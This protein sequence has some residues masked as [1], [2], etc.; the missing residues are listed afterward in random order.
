MTT[1]T[2][3]PGSSY[4]VTPL[5]S[6]RSCT[7]SSQRAD[8]IKPV[9]VTLLPVYPDFR[10][11]F[12]SDD[13]TA[14]IDRST[15]SMVTPQRQKI[16]SSSVEDASLVYQDIDAM[17]TAA[18]TASMHGLAEKSGINSASNLTNQITADLDRSPGKIVVK[19]RRKDHSNSFMSRI[20][21]FLGLW[22][23]QERQLSF[24]NDITEEL[25]PALSHTG[26]QKYSPLPFSLRCDLMKPGSASSAQNSLR[27]EDYRTKNIPVVVENDH[28]LPFDCATENEQLS[29]LGQAKESYSY[30]PPVRQWGLRHRR[31]RSL[32]I[33]PVLA[34]SGR[35][36]VKPS[37]HV[38]DPGSLIASAP[39]FDSRSRSMDGLSRHGPNLSV[40]SSL[41]L[42]SNLSPLSLPPNFVLV[43]VRAIGLDESGRR[44]VMGLDGSY[45]FK[46]ARQII[47]QEWKDEAINDSPSNTSTLDFA[48]KKIKRGPTLG[49]FGFSRVKTVSKLDLQTRKEN[50]MAR[51]T[52]YAKSVSQE[53]GV[54]PG[55]SFVGRVLETGS[56]VDK[57]FA[58][59]HDWVIGLVD[60]RKVS[61]RLLYLEITIY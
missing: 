43:Q 10:Q 27:S 56:V 23:K 18:Q 30:P 20:A 61:L 1:P 4:E 22:K 8:F 44:M 35:A 47:D 3:K 37:S 7:F 21:S 31:S 54:I 50:G 46:R 6:P 25:L 32:D 51:E 13:G 33:G 12:D 48:T 26:K 55:Q 15:D 5:P 14:I 60:I 24:P 57:S 45:K 40:D 36:H 19:T 16:G 52:S 53:A 59:R 29:H 58:A 38:S 11:D 39:S 41:W 49:W 17:A 28:K 2:S 34:R 42:S 9:P